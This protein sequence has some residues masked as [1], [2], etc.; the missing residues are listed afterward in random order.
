MN[1]KGRIEFDYRDDKTA[2]MVA[3]LLE[4][5]NKIA[6]KKLKLKTVNRGKKVIT[7]LEHENMGTF[8]AAIDDLIFSEKLI[9]DVIE[10]LE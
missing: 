6:P 5:D 4:I 3:E 9:S 8:F 1:A 7:I 10:G 2:G